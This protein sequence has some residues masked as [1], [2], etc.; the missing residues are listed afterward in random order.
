MGYPIGGMEMMPAHAVSQQL[1]HA[2]MYHVHAETSGPLPTP[3]SYV[4]AG[5]AKPDSN[6]R[7]RAVCHSA[8][9]SPAARILLFRTV[10]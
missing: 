2:H 1:H 8:S 6:T 10:S 4:H 9:Y 7:V 3:A 5:G